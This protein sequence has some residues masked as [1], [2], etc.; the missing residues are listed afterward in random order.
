MMEGLW[1]T[2]GRPGPFLTRYKLRTGEAALAFGLQDSLSQSPE[3]RG[4]LQGEGG[5]S[6]IQLGPILLAS[7]EG[8]QILS[9]WI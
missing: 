8:K 7:L 2:Q 1:D 5:V 9:G 4:Q 6:A 3:G